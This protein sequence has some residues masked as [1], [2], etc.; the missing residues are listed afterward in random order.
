MFNIVNVYNAVCVIENAYVIE[1]NMRLTQG[2][3]EVT[4]A[5]FGRFC[6][7]TLLKLFKVAS[8]SYHKMAFF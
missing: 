6:N 1:S 2:D 5:A 4:L 8:R 7:A 3:F